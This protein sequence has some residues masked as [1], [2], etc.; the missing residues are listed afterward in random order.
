M[1]IK[2]EVSQKRKSRKY[3]IGEVPKITAPNFIMNPA[4]LRN[5]LPPGKK[6][7]IKRVYWIT[8]WKDSGSSGQHC[9]TDR[10]EEI[11]IIFRGSANIILDD[12]GKGKK[13][14][15]LVDN[16]IVFVPRLVWHGFENASSDFLLLALT[17]TNYDAVRKGY[18]EDYQKF[19]KIVKK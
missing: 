6:F 2:K 17:T 5:Y 9:H 14:Y 12:D 15:K 10:E 18:C 1:V 16:N 8:D 19:K 7:V 3:L 4:E 11:F 13:K